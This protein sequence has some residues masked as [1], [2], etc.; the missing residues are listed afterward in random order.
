[1]NDWGLPALMDARS[2]QSHRDGID[3]HAIDRGQGN[4]VT[5]SYDKNGYEWLQVRNP[6]TG[7]IHYT[8]PNSPQ[9]LNVGQVLAGGAL[10]IVQGHRIENRDGEGSILAKARALVIE[11][12]N[13]TGMTLTLQPSA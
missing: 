1:M 7:T 11:N 5:L 6:E 2:I 13:T 10:E 3:I 9:T 4:G 12:P 8:G